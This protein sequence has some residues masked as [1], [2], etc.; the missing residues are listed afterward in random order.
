MLLLYQEIKEYN[1]IIYRLF[2]EVNDGKCILMQ[3]VHHL[4]SLF[5]V[6]NVLYN[7]SMLGLS[8]VFSSQISGL[9]TGLC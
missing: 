4:M 9:F 1:Y 5:I 8:L 7:L 3:H 2:E 6:L